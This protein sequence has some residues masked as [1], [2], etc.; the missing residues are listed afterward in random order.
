MSTPNN[1]GL[2][3]MA[4]AHALIA[5]VDGSPEAV[6]RHDRVGWIALFA[7]DC[8]IED[9]VG[10][11]PHRAGDRAV[12]GRFHDTFIAPNQIIFHRGRDYVDGL[13]VLR[14]LSLEIRMAPGVAIHVPMFLVYELTEESG[15]LRIK[16]LAAHWELPPMVQ[17]LLRCGIPAVRPALALGT[18][19]L[20]LQGVSG[21]LG[22][23]RAWFS[24]GAAGKRAVLESLRGDT[25]ALAPAADGK[26]I[27]AGD[28]VS[29]RVGSGNGEA[30]L[31]VTV[32]GNVAGRR[33]LWL[34]HVTPEGYGSVGEACR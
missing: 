11:R 15:A 29:L 13:D 31:Q 30:V 26:L 21:T 32:R 18:R 9:P 24:A 2:E 27:A 8:L 17:A 20:R 25:A 16:R 34:Q 3:P 1:A 19:M 23:L 6:M 28:C 33:R 5:F 10:A 14:D 22:F 12:I 7:D 4:T